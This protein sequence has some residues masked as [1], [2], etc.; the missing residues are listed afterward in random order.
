MAAILGHIKDTWNGPQPAKIVYLA[1]DNPGG[2]DPVPTLHA[3]APKL[4]IEGAAEVKLAITAV[5]V[6]PYLLQIQQIDPDF[7]IFHAAGR[8]P[9]LVLKEAAKLGIP[10]EKFIS[11]VWGFSEDELNLAGAA[12]E[13]YHGVSYTAF[14]ND[15]LPIF[16]EV[17][18]HYRD[19]GK[20]PPSEMNSLWYVRGFYIAPLLAEGLKHAVSLGKGRVSGELV[21]RGL[22][23]I[24]EFN[25]GGLGPTT[26]ITDTDHGGSRKVRLYQI[27]NGTFTLVRDWFEGPHT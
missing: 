7:V 22:E 10:R 25:A 6:S 21:K 13:G 12:A 4:G 1:A 2:R 20:G 27:R 23:S 5:D 18:R 24:T 11:F 26:T 14:P 16:E 8:T 3:L 15:H 9:A 17:R 19:Q